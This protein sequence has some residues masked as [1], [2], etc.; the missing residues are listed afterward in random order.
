MLGRVN[1][2]EP[3]WM[4]SVACA[5]SALSVYI[6]RMRQRSSA[7][8]AMFGKSSL[9]QSPDWPRCLNSQFGRLKYFTSLR[10][11]CAKA[12]SIFF[13]TWY[14]CVVIGEQLRLVVEGIDVRDAA[15]QVQKDDAL[16]LRREM[17][18]LRRERI[19]RRGGRGHQFGKDARQHE[20]PAEERA[21]GVAA[22]HGKRCRGGAP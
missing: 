7:R 20:R 12:S 21:E 11:F 17:R 14:G 8:S 19:L 22:V 10:L 16:R 18:R 2:T 15:A 9:I 1:E 4:P 5:W 6:E 3:V 13:G